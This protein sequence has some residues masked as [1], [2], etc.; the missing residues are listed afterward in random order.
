MRATVCR[1]LTTAALLAAPTAVG[2]QPQVYCPPGLFA[3]CV[4]MELRDGP[5]GTEVRLQNLQGSLGADEM[6]RLFLMRVTVELLPSG[7]WWHESPLGPPTGHGA[8]DSN[9]PQ[10]FVDGQALRGGGTIDVE[11]GGT[12]PLPTPPS[13]FRQGIGDPRLFY[14]GV[15]VPML[16]GCANPLTPQGL[17]IGPNGFIAATCPSQGLN[18]W[19]VLSLPYGLYDK[20]SNEFVR[21]TRASD[22]RVSWESTLVDYGQNPRA[23]IDVSCTAGV[24]CDMYSYD[25]VAVVPEPST[26]ALLGTGLLGLAGVARRRRRASLHLLVQPEAS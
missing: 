25:V 12:V 17:P 24:D 2:A 16:E 6:H 14:Y 13:G 11:F 23:V 1:I 7:V 15:G 10:Y 22:L 26:Y 21:W 20:T 5:T 18:G 8:V 19:L 4:A 3:G 9:R